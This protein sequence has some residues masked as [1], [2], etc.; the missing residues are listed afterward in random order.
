MHYRRK[1]IQTYEYENWKSNILIQPICYNCNKLGEC[2][3]PASR[4]LASTGYF[5]FPLPLLVCLNNFDDC[6]SSIEHIYVAG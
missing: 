6:N 2:D 4:L 1:Y 5:N 3:Y